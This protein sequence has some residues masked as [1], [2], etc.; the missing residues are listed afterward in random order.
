MLGLPG[1]GAPCSVVKRAL[2]ARNSDPAFV[3]AKPPARYAAPMSWRAK[4]QDWKISAL[5]LPNP[6]DT[7][8]LEPPPPTAKPS[9]ENVETR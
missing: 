5:R 8:K 2:L 3:W 7:A 6:C 9:L 4:N 1:A